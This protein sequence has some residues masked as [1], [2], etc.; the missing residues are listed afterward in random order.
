MEDKKY[1]TRKFIYAPSLKEAL[2]K[3]PKIP[4]DEIFID[5]TEKEEKTNNIADCIG[6]KY[7]DCDFPSE[8]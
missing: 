7:V 5:E 4:V 6:F 3:E 2:K 1:I 8:Y